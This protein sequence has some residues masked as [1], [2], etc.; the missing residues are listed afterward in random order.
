MGAALSVDLRRRVVEAY[1]SGNF[2]Y[3]ETA[4]NFRVGYATVNRWLRLAREAGSLE[5]KPLPGRVPRIDTAGLAFVRQLVA[6]HPDATL[7]ELTHAYEVVHGSRLATCIMHR[8]LSKLGLTR[9]K[10]LSTLR[11]E[12]VK[13]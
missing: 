6:D 5:A 3:E 12:S 10:R 11:S 9:K 7:R 8:A 2:T 1:S 13:T 4:Q